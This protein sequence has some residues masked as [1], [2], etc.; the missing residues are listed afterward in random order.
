MKRMRFGMD[1][2]RRRD[3]GEEGE[4]AHE[5]NRRIKSE[6]DRLLRRRL[7][8]PRWAGADDELEDELPVR[9]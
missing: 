1:D 2:A 9:A 8:R 6:R 5:R 4:S 7:A 3:A